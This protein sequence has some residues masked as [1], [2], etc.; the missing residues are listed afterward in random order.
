MITAVQAVKRMRG[1]SQA[2]H[3]LSDNGWHYVVKPPAIGQ[4]AAINEWL[5]ARL[6]QMV[7]IMTADVRPIVIP[8]LLARHCWP[9][10]P[11]TTDVIGIAS[12]FPVDPSCHSIYD[13]APSVIADKIANLDH[14][15]GA[16]AVDLWTGKNEFRQCTY[17]RNGPWW[18]CFIDH[19]GMFGG[20]DWDCTGIP[21]PRNLPARWAYEPMPT[22]QIDLWSRQICS[23]RPA[24]LHR[25]FRDVPDCW[26]ET[27]GSSDLT[28]LAELLLS[29]RARVRAMLQGMARPLLSISSV[30]CDNQTRNAACL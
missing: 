11:A 14:M 21:D 13:F 29:R 9:G 23:I 28:E 12:A 16:L 24:S 2:V 22:E 27:V 20:N 17:F 4:R 8:Q 1:K 25:L 6:F 7:G 18:V 3:M 10:L 15:I 19:K 26:A 30:S 5:G